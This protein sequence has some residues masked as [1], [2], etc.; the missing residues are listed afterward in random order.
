MHQKI[1]AATGNNKKN[2]KVTKSKYKY[3]TLKNSERITE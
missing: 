2:V 3:N 1:L